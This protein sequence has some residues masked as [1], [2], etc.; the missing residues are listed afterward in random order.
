[1]NV[2]KKLLLITLLLFSHFVLAEESWYQ[3]EVIVFDRLSPDLDGEQWQDQE[4]NRR[5]NMVELQQATL[6]ELIP[7]SILDK[8]R[9]RLDG[10]SR[11]FKLSS[12]FK[13][14]HKY[15]MARCTRFPRSAALKPI[16][17]CCNVS[18]CKR[19]WAKALNG[20]AD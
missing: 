2:F 8:S 5:D 6:T 1:M 11:Y 13:R 10:I 18:A 9:N 7:F 16:S 12:D 20:Q 4:F 17:A 3:V 15:C 19:C 14:C